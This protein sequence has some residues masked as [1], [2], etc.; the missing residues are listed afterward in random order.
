[1]KFSKFF[2]G[3]ATV[4]FL[5]SCAP[6][7]ESTPVSETPA[8]HTITFH[9]NWNYGEAGG[10]TG[11]N[12]SS[13][14]IENCI[15]MGSIQGDYST[16]DIACRNDGIIKNCYKDIN[17]TGTFN[18][19]YAVGM[20]ISELNDYWLYEVTLTWD[21]SKWNYYYVDILAGIYPTPVQK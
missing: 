13:A 5:A 18:F 19:S 4:L 3:L 15:V 17:I 12:E 20:T 2:V 7:G 1:M 9:A 11:V 21:S 16:G 6:T 10:I 8:E 14:I